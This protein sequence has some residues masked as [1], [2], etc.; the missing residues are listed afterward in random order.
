MAGRDEKLEGKQGMVQRALTAGR[1]TS[2]LLFA[3]L[4]GVPGAL[5][6]V[7]VTHPAQFVPL[8]FGGIVVGTAG[9]FFGT[10]LVLSTIAARRRRELF[11]IGWG[12]DAG[13]F[14]EGLASNYRH[15][16]LELRVTFADPAAD[17]HVERSGSAGP[18][19]AA[20]GLIDVPG[21]ARHAE[22]GATVLRQVAPVRSLDVVPPLLRATRALAAAS[23]AHPI[24]KLSVVLAK[25]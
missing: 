7:I 23:A 6:A 2:V 12:F 16:V 8:F 5:S 24:A 17:V 10:R 19:S 15:V 21:F 25:P 14:L 4:L 22:G 11:A 3:V 13:S 18:R 9:M 1:M 20:E